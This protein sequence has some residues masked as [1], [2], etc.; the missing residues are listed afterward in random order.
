ME[1]FLKGKTGDEVYVGTVECKRHAEP[2][3]VGRQHL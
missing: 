2:A 1:E 3:Q